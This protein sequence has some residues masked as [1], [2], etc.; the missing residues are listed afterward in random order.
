MGR[1]LG[2]CNF[3]VSAWRSAFHTDSLGPRKAVRLAPVTHPAYQTQCQHGLRGLGARGG[4]LRVT[5]LS[6]LHYNPALCFL[7]Q[8]QTSNTASPCR[9]PPA[10]TGGETSSRLGPA[11]RPPS[12]G[13]GP[14]N[15]RN[16][17]SPCPCPHPFMAALILLSNLILGSGFHPLFLPL[18]PT[19]QTSY[20]ICLNWYL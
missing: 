20:P 7:P 8:R 14:S 3:A 13:S 6:L 12:P 17:A 1:L 2:I 18:P 16:F 15:V 9:P 10:W 4:P 5:I 11:T 19:S